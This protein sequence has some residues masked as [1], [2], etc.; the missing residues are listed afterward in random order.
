MMISDRR[1]LL[2]LVALSGAVTLAP[3]PSR[4]E[5]SAADKETAREYMTQGR[6]HRA[7]GDHEK[8][9]E[10]FK[11]AHAIMNVPTT[12][13]ELGLTQIDLGMLIEARETLLAASR[14]PET[15]GEPPKFASSRAEAKTA[16]D[17]LAVRI[18][19][20]H[21]TFTGVTN[22]EGIKLTIDER[23]V[24]VVGLEVIRKINPGSH[25][26]VAR[27]GS[28]EK[29][30]SVELKE[31]ETLDTKIDLT[32]EKE[33]PPPPPPAP[34]VEEPTSVPTLA[35]IGFG[36]AGV[37]LIAGGVTGAMSFS[38]AS[39]VRDRCVDGRC[40]PST[41]DDLDKGKALGTISTVSF[42][43]AGVGAAVGVYALISR[44]KSPEKPAVSLYLG[45]GS[46]G[47]VGSF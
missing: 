13:L 45:P 30:S 4:A 21:L 36:V 7:K 8:A 16:A 47:L 24:P 17:G 46:A 41:H 31:G 10:A 14:H 19:T 23:D 29:K 37:G 40:P 25:A 44:P 15:P 28:T 20:L 42:V 6:A 12:G 11:A 38:A 5:A 3:A 1:V 27:V 26:L 34:A 9:L 43:L 18:P 22:A 35:W 2:V 39:S 33:T 32:P